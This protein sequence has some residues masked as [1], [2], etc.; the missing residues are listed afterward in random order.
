MTDTAYGAGRFAPASQEPGGTGGQRVPP[1]IRERLSDEQAARLERL[2]KGPLPARHRIAYRV[3]SSLFGT[4]FYVALFAGMEKRD[5]ARVRDAGER[6]W[7]A[8][9]AL[10][11]ALFGWAVLCAVV[12][13]V[14]FAVTGA[15]LLKSGLGIDLFEDHFVLHGVFFG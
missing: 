9:L 6:R 3:S 14:G 8:R 5:A 15:Y 1:D 12:F 4:R 11:A 2:L 13:I 7:I 10:D